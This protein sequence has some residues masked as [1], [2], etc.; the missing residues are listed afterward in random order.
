MAIYG[1]NKNVCIYIH[2]YCRKNRIMYI[3]NF[4]FPEF[5]NFKCINDDIKSIN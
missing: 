1:I 4:K 5:K 3:N 2:Q